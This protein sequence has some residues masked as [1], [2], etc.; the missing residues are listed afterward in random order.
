MTR[1]SRLTL[2]AALALVLATN[3][4]VLLDVSANRSGEPDAVATM[5]ERELPLPLPYGMTKEDSGLA[6]SVRWRAEGARAQFNQYAYVVNTSPEWLGRD[7][8]AE[9][10]FDVEADATTEEGAR[11]YNRMLPRRALLVLEYDGDAYRRTL[12]LVEQHLLEEEALAAANPGK[13]EFARRVDEARHSLDRERTVNSR[14]FVIDAGTDHDALRGKY[15]DATRYLI[16][17][18]QVRVVVVR[19]G[20]TPTGMIDGLDV[21]SLHV[22]LSVRRPLDALRRGS[23]SGVREGP[24]RYAATVTVGRRLEPWISDVRSLEGSSAGSASGPQ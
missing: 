2:V 15:P 17:G 9:L 8:L 3:G 5:T 19:P 21:G 20:T 7:K 4:V 16:M 1:S 6:L 11:R 14:L 22:P 10:G 24:P 23:S 18:G 12:D 13:G